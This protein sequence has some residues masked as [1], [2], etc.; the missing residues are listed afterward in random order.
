[1]QKKIQ[2]LKSIILSNTKNLPYKINFAITSACN[3][4]CATCNVWKEFQKNPKI[5]QNDLNIK[6]I[7]LI[8]KSLPPNT[9][10]L[11]LS[12]GEPFLREDIFEICR[13]AIKYIPKLSLISIPSNG[14][15]GKKILDQT[16]KIL[17]LKI[18]NL[19]L[20]FSLDG[21]EDLHNR[22]RG[23]KNGYQLT[24]NTYTKI[25]MLSKREPR[26]HVNLETT[27]SRFNLEYLKSFFM[28]LVKENHK[29]TI[30][31]AHTGYLYKNS[32]KTSKY[33]QIN[34]KEELKEIISLIKKTLSLTS[35]VQLIEKIYLEKI[36]NYYEK[37]KK[38][39]IPC[40]ALKSSLALDSKGNIFPCFMW[41]KK[42]AN[43]KQYNY[44]LKIF[45]EK[46]KE[47]ISKLRKAIIKEKCP[48]CWTP[49]EAYQ[50]IINDF[51][52]KIFPFIWLET[53]VAIK[54]QFL[55]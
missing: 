44:N 7:S 45:L 5:A 46:N 14:L 23:I 38:Q 47:K 11:S 55:L 32:P 20:N 24:W 30:T 53:L 28:N 15:L 16:K 13:A 36:V 21:P 49:C 4:R 18:P 1:M 9:T 52:K 42:L 17:S 10:W 54:E 31:L 29:I 34:N 40:I 39:P 43:I 25:L 35:P 50:S 19:F 12:G 2:T 22:I 3:S 41:G 6:E 48:N 26:L 51:L 33:T 37:P 8:F 27:I